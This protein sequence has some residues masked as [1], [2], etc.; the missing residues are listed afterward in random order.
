MLD[1]SD[2]KLNNLEPVYLQLILFVKRSLL[3][4]TVK[5]GET[6]PSR[7]GLAA[8][9]G[10]NPNTVQK[11]YK[12]MEDEGFVVTPRNA[13]SIIHTT[14][15]LLERISEELEREFIQGFLKQ[16]HANGLGYKRVIELI[17]QYWEGNV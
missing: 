13:A 6:L 12:L 17:S 11:A 16:A 5:N 10:I 4:G 3:S 9:L 1:F 15:D 2:L 7:R 14:P 8:Q